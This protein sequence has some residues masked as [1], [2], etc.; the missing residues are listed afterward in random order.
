MATPP[1]P[2]YAAPF[3]AQFSKEQALDYVVRK[4]IRGVHTADLVQ[5]LAVTVGTASVG[6]LTVQPVVLDQDTN[7]YVLAQAPIY[8]V[9]FLRYQSGPSAVIMD[10]VEGDIGLCIFAEKDIT[11]V[12]ARAIQAASS[13]AGAA[14]TDRVHSS[15][16][17]LY[18]GGVLNGAPTQ[19]VKFLPGAGGIDIK[20]PGPLTIEATGNVT[21]TA[22]EVV[23]DAP[24]QI[25]STLVTTGNITCPDV[26]VG[27]AGGKSVLNH[28]HNLVQPGTGNSG[29]MQG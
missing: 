18:I 21:I 15:A 11:G 14:A 29:G 26:I 24:V 1:A 28:F 2:K 4:I 12:K 25:N 8:N 9:P 22:N 19:W 16:D 17:A 3:E 5:V 23:I 27:G 7:G 20:T 6:F 10:P 13:L